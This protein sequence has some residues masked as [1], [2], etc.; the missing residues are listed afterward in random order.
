[1]Y[2]AQGLHVFVVIYEAMTDPKVQSFHLYAFFIIIII[3]N[4]SLCLSSRDFFITKTLSQ[5]CRWAA[6]CWLSAIRRS[7]TF[8]GFLTVAAPALLSRAFWWKRKIRE[9]FQ[10]AAG[11]YYLKINLVK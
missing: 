2:E 5:K 7:M 6:P 4:V 1:M 9:L 3:I 11:F 8:G 10:C